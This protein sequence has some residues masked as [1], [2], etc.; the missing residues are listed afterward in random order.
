MGLVWL[1]LETDGDSNPENGAMKGFQSR[2]ALIL[3][4]FF[5]VDCIIFT[6]I[7]PSPFSPTGVISTYF[8]WKSRGNATSILPYKAVFAAYIVGTCIL[9]DKWNKADTEELMKSARSSA[10]KQ[11]VGYITNS[12]LLAIFRF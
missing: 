11:M 12:L 7:G 10:Q 1:L 9:L 4:T 8:G 3:L 5:L 6:L 2:I